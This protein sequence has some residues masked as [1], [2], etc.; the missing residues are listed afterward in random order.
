MSIIRGQMQHTF[1]MLLTGMAYIEVVSVPVAM[2]RD[3]YLD[4]NTLPLM[5]SD[6]ASRRSMT[7]QLLQEYDGYNHPDLVWSIH[8]YGNARF[9][10]VF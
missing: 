6:V 8:G 2:G 1:Q 10:H 9:G 4:K 7:G 5:L 3:Y